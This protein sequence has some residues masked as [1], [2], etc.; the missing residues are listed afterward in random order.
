[1]TGIETQENCP[2]CGAVTFWR[3]TTE[4]S[5]KRLDAAPDPTGT[6]IILDLP[7]GTIRAK[8]LTGS[9]LP[10][11]QEAWR[12]HTCTRRTGAPDP[13]CAVCRFA[14]TPGD[15]FRAM[16]WTT[17][18]GIGCDSEYQAEVARLAVE[19]KRAARELRRTA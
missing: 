17:H 15:F 19:T 10:A 3:L 1:V 14:M 2:K 11:Q 7:D 8:C 9:E 12:L 4:G 16:R 13:R 5:R 18:P 6:V